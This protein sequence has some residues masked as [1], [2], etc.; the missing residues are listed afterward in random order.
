MEPAH[1]QDDA[2]RAELRALLPTYLKAN[3]GQV[4]FFR[5]GDGKMHPLR[6]F[7]RDALVAA[8]LNY[9]YTDRGWRILASRAHIR[10]IGDK[11]PR[12]APQPATPRQRRIAYAGRTVATLLAIGAVFSFGMY[13]VSPDVPAGA[14]DT[15]LSY[16]IFGILASAIIGCCGEI[17]REP[18]V[19]DPW[20][21]L[22]KETAQQ[23]MLD[24]LTAETQRS[25]RRVTIPQVQASFDALRTAWGEYTLNR[26]EYFLDMPLLRDR[27]V[28][29]TLAY[30]DAMLDLEEAL[31]TLSPGSPQSHVER[32]ATLADATWHAWHAAEIKISDREPTERAA[33]LRL[34]RLVQR[35]AHETTPQQERP[36]ILAEIQRCIS[37]IT[38]VPVTWDTVR[39]LPEL[40]SRYLPQLLPAPTKEEAPSNAAD[41]PEQP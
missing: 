8:G 5:G 37:Q 12:F 16:A 14:T 19:S 17:A 1:G 21:E 32:A 6:A 30:Q 28:P 20:I 35:L 34:D 23:V 3:I 7:D 41:E 22:V 36:K 31:N 24:R 15:W 26:A 39:A 27:T 40:S 10:R 13:L 2:T 18:A 38:T 29:E 9:D 33:L 11:D 4:K 25:R